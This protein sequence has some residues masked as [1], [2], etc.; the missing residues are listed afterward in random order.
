VEAVSRC[1]AVIRWVDRIERALRTVPH[2]AAN[3]ALSVFRRAKAGFEPT[4]GEVEAFRRFATGTD[5]FRKQGLVGDHFLAIGLVLDVNGSEEREHTLAAIDRAIDQ[6]APSPAGQ[7]SLHKLGQPYVNVYLDASLRSA[8][9]YFL[10]FGGFV[11]VFNLVLYRSLRT[12]A[13]FLITLGVCLAASLGYIGATGGT[14]IVTHGADDDSG[15]GDRDLGVPHS[16]FVGGQRAVGRRASSVRLDQQVRRVHRIDLRDGGGLRRVDGLNIR[17]IHGWVSGRHWTGLHLGH[18]VHPL[19]ALQGCCGRPPNRAAW[20]RVAHGRRRR[21]R[22]ASLALGLI[23][24][25]WC[26]ARQTVALFGAPAPSGGAL[27]TDPVEYIDHASP[28]YQDIRRLQ[29]VI[30]GLSIAGV[31]QGLGSVSSRPC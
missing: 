20:R 5:L 18:R 12:L 9:R 11:V 19:S 8:W 21:C 3:S 26:W 2:V 29:P 4:A 22:A 1:P 27:L 14:L 16:R 25:R 10:L 28:L 13:A 30:P 24:R 7:Q 17:P 15:H 6:S 23:V 31:A